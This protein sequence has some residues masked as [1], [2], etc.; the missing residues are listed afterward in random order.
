MTAK[1]YESIAICTV[2]ISLSD[3]LYLIEILLKISALFQGRGVFFFLADSLASPH[4]LL[5]VG[6]KSR[7]NLVLS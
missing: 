2:V 5:S 3:N 7:M 1:M 6:H 4:Y